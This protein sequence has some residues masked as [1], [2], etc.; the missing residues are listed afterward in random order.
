[1]AN[2]GVADVLKLPAE[3]PERTQGGDG[4]QEEGE[5]FEMPA[6]REMGWRP[7]GAWRRSC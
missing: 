3:H 2:V 4:N 6:L 5:P 1:M 7:G